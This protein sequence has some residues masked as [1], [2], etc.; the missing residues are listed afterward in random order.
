MGDNGVA[1][2]VVR[3]CTVENFEAESPRV[4]GLVARVQ[5]NAVI[6]S[7]PTVITWKAEIMNNKVNNCTFRCNRQFTSNEAATMHW[8]TTRPD[9]SIGAEAD[10]GNEFSGN[11]YFFDGIEYEYSAGVFTV[12]S[13]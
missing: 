6:N 11:K 9:S 1:Y 7:E 2:L 4:T 3:N 8:A 5:E 12:K 13:I 10:E